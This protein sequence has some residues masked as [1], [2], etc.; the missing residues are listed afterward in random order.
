MDTAHDA[1]HSAVQCSLV[2]RSRKRALILPFSHFGRLFLYTVAVSLSLL[3]LW[4]CHRTGQTLS[5]PCSTHPTT[6]DSIVWSPVQIL[7]PRRAP[8]GVWFFDFVH[9][10]SHTRDVT[11]CEALG[12]LGVVGDA[13][14]D[15]SSDVERRGSYEQLKTIPTDANPLAFSRSSLALHLLFWSQCC[16]WLRG[17]GYT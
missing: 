8:R 1:G 10:R 12:T 15:E 5:T 3:S 17:A 14:R 4:H 11:S 2:G 9:V 16:A 6:L 7:V 13:R